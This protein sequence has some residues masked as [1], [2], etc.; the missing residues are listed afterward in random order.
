MP[1]IDSEKLS[2][3]DLDSPL[4]TP[5]RIAVIG[6]GILGI[7][8]ALYGRYLGYKVSVYEANEIGH[9]GRAMGD[10]PLPMLPDRSFSPLAALALSAQSSDRPET[11]PVTCEDWVEQILIPLTQTDLLV[12]QVHQHAEVAGISHA[13]PPESPDSDETDDAIPA[14]FELTFVDQREPEKFEALIIAIE[15]DQ[16]LSKIEVG[17]DIPTPYLFGVRWGDTR[18]PEADFAVG[19][20]RIVSVYANLGDRNDLDL[21]APR[22]V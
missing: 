2:Q 18:S 12:G 11:L 16:S 15:N 22:R 17:F 19:L 21:Y 5:G 20:K 14:D 10:Q 8:A 7:E 13:V 3:P 6:G 1:Q 9:T 4:E